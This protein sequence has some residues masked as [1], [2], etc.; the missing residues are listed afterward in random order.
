[1]SDA[2]V[3]N[4]TWHD[5]LKPKESQIKRHITKVFRQEHAPY[6]KA[7][8]AYVWNGI[9]W[10]DYAQQNFLMELSEAHDTSGFAA[11][12][13]RRDIYAEVYKVWRSDGT[14]AYLN[15]T[16]GNVLRLFDPRDRYGPN[17]G[18][19]AQYIPFIPTQ[20][21][22]TA[23]SNRLV[24]PPANA[25]DP[26]PP[27]S[28]DCPR[29]R[30]TGNNAQPEHPKQPQPG[31]ARGEPRAGA[32]ASSDSQIANPQAESLHPSALPQE[33]PAVQKV[34]LGD[35][36]YPQVMQFLSKDPN[37]PDLAKL[38]GKVTGRILERNNRDIQMI[39]AS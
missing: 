28:R 11:E 19:P 37:W 16:H 22:L 25:G 6:D 9:Q 33:N 36:L 31:T 15:D 2:R 13:F 17:A 35:Q 7:I 23:I 3:F 12:A 38:A 21:L 32:A 26:G 24:P 18:D 20:V 39:I 27:P 14:F 8:S 30:N 10:H 34:K 1:M 5:L 4:P 29:P